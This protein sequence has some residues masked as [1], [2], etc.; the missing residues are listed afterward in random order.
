MERKIITSFSKKYVASNLFLKGSFFI[1]KVNTQNLT[2]TKHGRGGSEAHHY[3]DNYNTLHIDSGLSK[4]ALFP[5]QI[6]AS[7]RSAG[8]NDGIVKFQTLYRPAI[9]RSEYITIEGLRAGHILS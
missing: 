5:S 9:H 4:F 2:G 6:S 7:A 3:D 1:F 8:R